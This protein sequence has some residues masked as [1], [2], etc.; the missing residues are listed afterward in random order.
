MSHPQ[1]NV[2]VLST[3]YY[4]FRGLILSPCSK[5]LPLTQSGVRIS[6][7][8][9]KT[10]LSSYVAESSTKMSASLPTAICMHGDTVDVTLGMKGFHA[11]SF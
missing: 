9:A 10:Y 3:S 1:C 2:A 8:F 4:N 7:P 5:A 11:H 6:W